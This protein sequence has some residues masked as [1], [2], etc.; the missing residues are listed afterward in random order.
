MPHDAGEGSALANLL[1]VKGE[2][3]VLKAAKSSPCCPVFSRVASAKKYA[4]KSPS[5]RGSHRGR[6]WS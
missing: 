6:S 5:F 3:S 1:G 4:L 2:N